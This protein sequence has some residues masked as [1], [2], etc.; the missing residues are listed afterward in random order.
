M[1][2]PVNF[3]Y[4]QS[5]FVYIIVPDEHSNGKESNCKLTSNGVGLITPV[6]ISLNGSCTG[7]SLP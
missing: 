2:F 3:T 6:S 7:Q 5:N 1:T 4:Y